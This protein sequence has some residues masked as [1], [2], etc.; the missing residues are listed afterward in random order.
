MFSGSGKFDQRRAFI[1]LITQASGAAAVALLPLMSSEAATRTTL[2]SFKLAK[3]DNLQ[4]YFDLD[5]G[6][7]N[8]KVFALNNP[9]RLVIDLYNVKIN[10]RMK[11]D[12]IHSDVVKNIRYATHNGRNVRIVVDLYQP[13]RYD[14]KFVNRQG[15]AKRLVID[16]GVDVKVL[17]EQRVV[18]SASEVY[19]NQNREIVVVIDPGHGGKDPGAIGRKKTKEKDITLAVA[20]KLEKKLTNIQGIKAVMTRNKDKYVGLRQRMN[21][22]RKHNA[23]LF[24]SIHADAFPNKQARGSSVYALSLKGASS[25]AAQWLADKENSADLFGGVSLDGRSEE[26]KKTLIDLAQNATLESSLDIGSIMLKHIKQVSH[27]HKKDVEQASFAVLRSPDIP[28]ILVET[29]FLTNPKEEKKLRSRAFQ[30]RLATALQEATLDYLKR[31]AP[32]GSLLA[33]RMETQR[34]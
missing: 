29:A 27:L 16:L 9:H 22:A 32:P 15:N 12:G 7:V 1:R 14:F 21:T 33:S 34:S 11:V 30:D 2:H 8:H 17:R 28:S 26:L 24:I 20:R 19:K 13:I 4:L 25:E 3:Q 18:K 31:K 5:G 10:A 23:E 6:V